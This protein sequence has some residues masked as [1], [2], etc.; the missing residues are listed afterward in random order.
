MPDT[1]NRPVFARGKVRF[2]GDIVAAVVADTR[3]QAIDAAEAVIVDYDPL[4]SVL[5][6]GQALAPDAPLLFPEH[7]SNICFGTQ[8]PEGDDSD[9]ITGAA[10]VGEVT[11][12][13][14]RL[15]GVP[16]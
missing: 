6:A 16:M 8:F 15:A 13:S 9:P 4:P 3:A 10:A 1:L 5:T 7:G 12:V 2:V 11:M 14:Q